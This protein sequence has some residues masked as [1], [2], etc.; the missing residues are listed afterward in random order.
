LLKAAGSSHTL[1]HAQQLEGIKMVI[2]IRKSLRR[3]AHSIE[4]AEIATKL[5]GLIKTKGGVGITF[6]LGPTSFLF[7]NSHLAAHQTKV[8]DRNAD[9]H[10]I[11]KGLGLPLDLDTSRNLGLVTTPS[12][13]RS[14]GKMVY[15]HFD[16]TFWMGDLN[17]RIDCSRARVIDAVNE[18]TV[19]DLMKYDQL[20]REKGSGRVFKGFT[21]APVRFNPTYKFDR[22]TDIFDSSAKQRVPAWT[23]RILYRSKAKDAIEC[24]C[25]EAVPELKSSDH[26]PV[27]ASFSVGLHQGNSIPCPS[28]GYQTANLMM[29][30]LQRHKLERGLLPVDEEAAEPGNSSG[31]GSKKVHSKAN[32]S[33][34]TEKKSSVCT[35][36]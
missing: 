21:E 30:M 25:Y 22:G 1:L 5:G 31:G 7:I 15:D 8:A 13:S 27:M 26:R 16:N 17:Y 18:G 34:R 24:H 29:S 6:K 14:R 2:I 11:C 23:D 4:S 36:S 12:R 20:W 32:S 35:I 33:Y 28:V 19:S 3:Y 10:N 9:Y